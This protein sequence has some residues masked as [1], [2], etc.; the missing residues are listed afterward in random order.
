MAALSAPPVGPDGARPQKTGSLSDWSC[1]NRTLFD[2]K[3][4]DRL[5]SHRSGQ[6]PEFDATLVH[7]PAEQG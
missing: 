2:E 4:E 1:N 6:A 5:L 3:T 7:G